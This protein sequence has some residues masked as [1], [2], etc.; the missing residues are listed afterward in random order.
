MTPPTL[1]PCISS[2]S[3]HP[4]RGGWDPCTNP[5]LCEQQEFQSTHP[6]GGGTTTKAS[7]RQRK[8]ISIHPPRGGWDRITGNGFDIGFL[9]QSTHPVGGGT[10]PQGPRPNE[11][12]QFQSTHPVGGGTI[13]SRLVRLVEVISIHPPRGGWDYFRH[14]Q[15][16]E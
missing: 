4:P 6:V 13:P 11:T 15:R 5:L 9:F 2:I 14:S 12:R 10:I 3:I 1:P 8:N 16:Y 7:R